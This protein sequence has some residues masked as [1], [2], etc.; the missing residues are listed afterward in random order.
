LQSSQFF[1]RLN[2][3]IISESEYSIQKTDQIFTKANKVVVP[4]L[5][6]NVMQ[7]A[8][9]TIWGEKRM[10]KGMQRVFLELMQNTHN[11]ASFEQEG[12]MFWWLSV[13]HDVE[14]KKVSFV[15]VDYGLGIFESLS[16][17]PAESKWSGYLQKIKTRVGYENNAEILH[18][19]LDGELH[20]TV[21]G[22]S[23]RG[24]GLPGIREVLKRNQI[25]NLR[26]ISNNVSADVFNAQYNLL[27][28]KFNG[29]FLYWE[30]CQ[31]NEN[32]IWNI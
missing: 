8:S 19:L 29:T 28:N 24:K 6:Y 16:N 20:L 26:I 22:K 3:P 9:K 7:E 27:G 11:H 25:S 12:E 15:F 23:F 30:L 1:D 2:K 10:C 18:K 13:N 21:T 17:K 4:L 32:K 5:G 14:N 31:S